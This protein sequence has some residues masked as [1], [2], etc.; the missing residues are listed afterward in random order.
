MRKKKQADKVD[1]FPYLFSTLV[2]Q[3][4]IVL[5][6]MF[7]ISKIDNN[8]QDRY[9]K[10]EYKLSRIYDRL[11]IIDNRSLMTKILAEEIHKEQQRKKGT[12]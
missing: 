4:I 6:G 9:K 3:V 10:L 7:M 5:V 1:L 12:K 8:N 11:D 2:V